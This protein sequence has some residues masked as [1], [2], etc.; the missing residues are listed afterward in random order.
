MPHGPGDVAQM[1]WRGDRVTA[2]ELICWSF[3]ADSFSFG[4]DS[5]KSYRSK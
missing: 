3:P 2:V 5:I 4:L 1:P